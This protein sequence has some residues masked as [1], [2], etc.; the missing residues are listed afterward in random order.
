M[1]PSQQC[2]YFDDRELRD[3]SVT[4][5]AAGII[6]NATL[7]LFVDRTVEADDTAALEQLSRPGNAARASART[8]DGFA[9]SLLLGN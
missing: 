7:Q 9:G 4:L 1:S 5:A 6:A 8:E 3:P 2:I